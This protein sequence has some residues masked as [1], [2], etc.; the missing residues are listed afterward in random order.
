[1]QVRDRILQESA[2]MLDGV[3]N[4]EE[5]EQRI[6]ETLP[7]LQRAAED[8]IDNAAIPIRLPW[9]WNKPTSPPENMSR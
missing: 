7:A 5:A 4:K 6:R 3:R 2:G 8:E 1:M 9:S